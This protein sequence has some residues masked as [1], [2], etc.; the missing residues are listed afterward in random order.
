MFATPID[1]MAYSLKVSQKLFHRMVDDLKP[2]EFEFQAI[3]G[4][5][6]ASWIIGHLVL[7]DRRQL[8]ALGVGNLPALSEGF[9]KQFTATRSAA[10]TQSGFGDPQEL[11]A[12]FDDY[13]DRLIAALPS[14]EPARWNELPSLNNPLFSDRGE[15]SLFL[16]LH[17]SM[18][19]GQLSMI[20]RQLGYPPVV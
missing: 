8:V 6:C 19:I 12:L 18:H 4:S 15:T 11:I 7:S 5:N 16:G 3:P 20:R 9:E 10:D 2:H 13:R 1:A 14:V 17:T